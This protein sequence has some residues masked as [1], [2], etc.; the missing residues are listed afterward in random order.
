M[1]P[2]HAPTRSRRSSGRCWRWHPGRIDLGLGRAPGTDPLT[3]HVLRRGIEAD[4]AAEFPGQVAELLAFLGDPRAAVPRRP[5]VRPAGR[6]RRSSTSVPGA[7]RP[8]LQ[9]LRHPVR[10]RERH[11]DRLRPPHDARTWRSRHCSSTGREFTPGVEARAVLGDVG[12]RVRHRRRRRRSPE[13]EAGWTLTH[14]QPGPRHPGAAAA[15]GGRGSRRVAGVPAARRGRRPDGHRR[16]PS[17]WSSGC[18]SCRPS[19][20]DEIVVVT[21]SLDR[22]RRIASFERIARAWS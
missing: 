22:A 16:V 17:P 2:N 15:R 18:R 20:V 11:A 14:G 9:R 19:T 6:R 12:A 4:P 1:L 8:R 21:P 10:R 3:A 5:P 13:F 7:V